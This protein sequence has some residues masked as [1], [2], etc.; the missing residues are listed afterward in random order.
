MNL[1]KRSWV[2]KIV[3]IKEINRKRLEVLLIGLM[4]S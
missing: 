1:E 4:K 3:P 2:S